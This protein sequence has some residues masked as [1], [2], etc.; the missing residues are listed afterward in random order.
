MKITRRKLAAA[1]ISPAAMLAQTPPPI[2]ANPTEE[3]AAAREQNRRNA[4]TL[5]EFPLPMPVEPAFHFKA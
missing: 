3:L 4:Q 1:L 2:P 5:D